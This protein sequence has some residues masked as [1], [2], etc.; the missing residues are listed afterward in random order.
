M[1]SALDRPPP[2]K[3]AKSAAAHDLLYGR[4]GGRRLPLLSDFDQDL[5]FKAAI[6]AGAVVYAECFCTAWWLAPCDVGRTCGHCGE[7]MERVDLARPG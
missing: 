4:R 3:R 7:P 5:E 6:A 2:S 1:A